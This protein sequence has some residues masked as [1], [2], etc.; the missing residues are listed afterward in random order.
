MSQQKKNLPPESVITNS[1]HLEKRLDA[2]EELKKGN[3]L[4][5][6]VFELEKEK[7]KERLLKEYYKTY[8]DAL[9]KVETLEIELKKL[10]AGKKVFEET[11]VGEFVEKKTFDEQTVQKIK[12]TKETLEKIFKAID[13]AMIEGGHD[14]WVI[15]QKTIR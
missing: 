6:E 12:K 5:T 15:L 1:K 9:K 13:G 2:F 3:S 4:S 11:T 7:E 14:K 10:K 8:E